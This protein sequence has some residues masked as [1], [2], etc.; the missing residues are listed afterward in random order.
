MKHCIILFMGVLLVLLNSCA[1]NNKLASLQDTKGNSSNEVANLPATPV[2]APLFPFANRNIQASVQQSAVS[3]TNGFAKNTVVASGIDKSSSGKVQQSIYSNVRINGKSLATGQDTVLTTLT[4]NNLAKLQLKQPT[5]ADSIFIAESFGKEYQYGHH[6]DM[7][8][9]K[10]KLY[11]KKAIENNSAAAMYN[12]GTLYWKETGANRN[13]AEAFKLFEKAAALNYA[14]AMVSLAHMYHNEY[15]IP[16]DFAKAF[17]LYKQAA[18]LNN[19]NGIYWTGYM[20]YKGFG[21]QQNYQNAIDYFTQGSTRGETRCLYMLGSCY[22]HGYGVTQNLEK[23]QQFFTKALVK[24]ND[25]AIYAAIYHIMDS[26]KCHPHLSIASLPA[27]MPQVSDSTNVDLLQGRWS[28]K[29][30]TYDRSGRIVENE[31]DMTIELQATDRELTGSW[32]SGNRQIVQFTAAKDTASWKMGATSTDK[33]KSSYFRL[34]SLTC[35]LNRQYGAYNLTGN[36]VRIERKSNE[37]L[38]PTYF[39]LYKKNTEETKIGQDTTFVLNRIYPN[40]MTDQLTIDFT[41]LKT[42]N[43][44]FQI[45]TLAGVPCYSATPKSYQQGVYSITI[46]PSLI[47]GSY[48]FVALGKQY[49]LTRTIIKK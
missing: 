39:V 43:I 14:P 32:N 26:A 37:P 8:V 49:K 2:V 46:H 28:G 27:A 12:L 31:T 40:P 4:R 16:Q 36:L 22:L 30:Y 5:H 45:R 33:D 25:H 47:A 23:A 44:S 38:R 9:N 1:T 35:K 24:G 18:D 42:D 13:R 20:Y 34:S 29:L 17:L 15:G 21:T 11:Y 6:M 41:V 10:A 7:N 48:N 3:G 19:K